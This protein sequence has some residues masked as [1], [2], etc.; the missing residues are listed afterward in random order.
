[1]I[2][3]TLRMRNPLLRNVESQYC[4]IYVGPQ[5]W[6]YVKQMPGSVWL[7]PNPL[8]NTGSYVLTSICFTNPFYK[9]SYTYFYRDK[10][11]CI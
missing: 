4:F 9:E 7:I 5:Q 3:L 6:R 2:S 1:M 11:A 10:A 8:N